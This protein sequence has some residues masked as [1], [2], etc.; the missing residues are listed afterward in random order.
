MSSFIKFLGT[1]GG[2]YVVA[3][4]LRASGGTYISANGQNIILD[5]GPGALVK[6]AKSKPLIDAAS[7][8]GIIL[9]HLH[10]DHSNDVNILIDAITGGGHRKGGVLFAPKEALEGDN[11]VVLKYLRDFLDD[12][13]ILEADKE[14][15]IGGLKF[16]TSI[17]HQHTT[18]TYGIK[19]NINGRLVSFIT[20]T[21]F[22]PE[23]ID[24]YKNSDILI[25]NVVSQ[26][27]PEKFRIKH[28]CLDD[29]K[30]IIK[31][32]KPAKVIITHFGMTMLKAKPWKLAEEITKELGIEVIAASDGMTMEL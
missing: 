17:K 14:Y 20:D 6:C 7:L 22:F 30:E 15:K 5:P 16:S 24:S 10:I 8:N 23:L 21:K 29:V 26:T 4:Q 2:R 3:R 31:G 13:V 27:L 12:I 19:F 18:E 25:V 28:L 1:A 32:V 11:A 9:T